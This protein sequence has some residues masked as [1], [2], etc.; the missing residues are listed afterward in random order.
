MQTMSLFPASLV[1]SPVSRSTVLLGGRK[2][3]LLFN[4]TVTGNTGNKEILVSRVLYG[5]VSLTSGSPDVIS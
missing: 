2:G 5:T 1:G 3:L 4:R